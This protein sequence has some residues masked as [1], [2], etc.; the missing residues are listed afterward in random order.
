MFADNFVP[1]IIE[2]L[3]CSEAPWAN[4]SIDM[5]QECVNTLYP[6]LDYALKKGDALISLVTILP[7]CSTFNICLPITVKGTNHELPELYWECRRHQSSEIHVKI[8]GP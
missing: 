5:L 6:S 2:E 4:L 7:L 3:G 8:Q 1:A